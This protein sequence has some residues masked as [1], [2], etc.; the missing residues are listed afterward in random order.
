[1]YLNKN[2]PFLADYFFENCYALI[3]I[4][5]QTNS[6]RVF[7]YYVQRITGIVNM[8]RQSKNYS[9]FSNYSILLFI[10]KKA[11][12]LEILPFILN[13]LFYIFV[14]NFFKDYD[15]LITQLDAH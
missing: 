9:N 13:N 14:K 4:K 11:Q 10:K 1:M 2:S 6:F 12:T 8:V 7:K 15:H 5:I 3:P